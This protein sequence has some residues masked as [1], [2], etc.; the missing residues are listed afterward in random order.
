MAGLNVKGRGDQ[1]EK[2]SEK[3]SFT[4]GNKTRPRKIQEKEENKEEEVQNAQSK[5]REEFGNKLRKMVKKIINY[6]LK[7]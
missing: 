7:F 3:L 2:T 6:S 5:R 4:D 1:K